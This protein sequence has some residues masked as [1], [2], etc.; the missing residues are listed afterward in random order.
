MILIKRRLI[1]A[2]ESSSIYAWQYFCCMNYCYIVILA[3]VFCKSWVKCMITIIFCSLNF[4]LN[5]I[6]SNTQVI[7]MK[8]NFKL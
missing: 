3:G 1:S 7:K 4:F 6:H 8:T 2:S 5:S